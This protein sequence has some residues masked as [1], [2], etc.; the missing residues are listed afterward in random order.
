MVA[1]MRGYLEE[2]NVEATIPMGATPTVLEKRGMA[3]TGKTI[4]LDPQQPLVITF[5]VLLCGTSQIF[6]CLAPY[7]KSIRILK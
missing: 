1:V 2:V 6:F 4:F 7:R 5:A 3:V